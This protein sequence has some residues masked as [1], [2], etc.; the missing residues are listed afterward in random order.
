MKGQKHCQDEFTGIRFQASILM[1]ELQSVNNLKG[2][3]SWGTGNYKVRKLILRQKTYETP[4]VDRDLGAG[5]GRQQG[6]GEQSVYNGRRMHAAW[7]RERARSLTG[8]ICGRC[9][10]GRHYGPGKEVGSGCN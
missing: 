7:G 10:G 8:D 4:G 9:P 6:G 3:I 1:V 2:E 5:Q